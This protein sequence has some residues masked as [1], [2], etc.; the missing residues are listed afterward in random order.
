MDQACRPI[1]R[2][3]PEVISSIAAGEVIQKP[4]NAVKE[5][6]ENALDAGAT[7]V[8]V[9]VSDGGKQFLSIRDNG[10]GMS[11]R[12]PP[13][14]VAAG[15]S[16]T[17]VSL[18]ICTWPSSASLPASSPGS[19]YQVQL[20]TYYRVEDLKSL[21]TYGFRG[22]ALASISRVSHLTIVSMQ[23]SADCATE[24]VSSLLRSLLTF[25]K[26]CVPFW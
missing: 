23:E 11:V 10:K 13:F 25:A 24:Y 18:P 7:E 4:A 15:A 3:P 17:C 8:D 22:E 20:L 6:L 26:S 21:R 2:L 1:R 12:C 16:L 19:R 5:L 14:G 9:S